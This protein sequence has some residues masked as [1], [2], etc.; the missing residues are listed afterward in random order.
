MDCHY[1]KE[2]RMG[3]GTQSNRLRFQ[4]DPTVIAFQFLNTQKREASQS[5][6]TGGSAYVK[7]GNSWD[8]VF[9]GVS[10]GSIIQFINDKTQCW[11]KR[12]S[13][14]TGTMDGFHKA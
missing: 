14:S 10:D 1:Q 12:R 9:R 13:S 2:D 11:K 3:D 5:L 7:D 4:D 8:A 6:K